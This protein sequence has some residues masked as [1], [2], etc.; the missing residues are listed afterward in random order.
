MKLESFALAA[1][2]TAVLSNACAGGSDFQ[3]PEAGAGGGGG[4]TNDPCGAACDDA[5][6]GGYEGGSA[7]DAGKADTGNPFPS[8]DSGKGS[9]GE[10]GEPVADSSASKDGP[11]PACAEEMT[12][13]AC[14]SCCA[15]DNPSAIT[16]L[17]S[18]IM[19]CTCGSSGPCSSACS[20]EVCVDVPAT[21]GDA[22][23]ACLSTA[24]GTTGPCYAPVQTACLADPGC[25]AYLSCETAECSGL[26]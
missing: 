1:I 21:E 25:A 11:D 22:C 8:S 14:A 17:N 2:V 26:P 18:A 5:G 20:T 13:S 9:S 4:S 7:Y 24:L 10:G 6:S 3:D 16:T 19:A 12:Q 15:A 23:Y